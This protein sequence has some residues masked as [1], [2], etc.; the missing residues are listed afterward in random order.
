MSA[1]Y[2]LNHCIYFSYCIQEL[3]HVYFNV[4]VEWKNE[5][6]FVNLKTI[7]HYLIVNL[8]SF[9]T[10]IHHFSELDTGLSIPADTSGMPT[11]KFNFEGFSDRIA[12]TYL[13]FLHHSIE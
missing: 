9:V 12:I 3:I 13:R 11:T 2:S 4:F 1:S 10:H 6:P 5:L 7:F 8:D